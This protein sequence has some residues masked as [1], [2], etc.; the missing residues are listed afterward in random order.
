MRILV[1]AKGGV[2]L[3]VERSLWLLWSSSGLLTYS[4]CFGEEC[5]ALGTLPH[6][7]AWIGRGDRK[8][9]T[10]RSRTI[11]LRLDGRRRPRR[12]RRAKDTDRQDGARGRESTG[13]SE[14]VGV[15]PVSPSP[16][17]STVR[18]RRGGRGHVRRGQ[19]NCCSS[20]RAN[21]IRD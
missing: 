1:C 21:R 17:G 18:N 20:Q 12:P 14:A 9:T 5:W 6:R 11:W 16:G 7:R 15:S 8:D 13:G 10:T 2:L 4:S 19:F 3:E